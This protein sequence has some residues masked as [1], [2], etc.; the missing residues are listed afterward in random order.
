MII[1]LQDREKKK[2]NCA[3]CSVSPAG[4]WHDVQ[5]LSFPQVREKQ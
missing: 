2:V 1:I 5:R 4:L 3:N